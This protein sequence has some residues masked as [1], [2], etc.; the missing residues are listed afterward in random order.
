MQTVQWPSPVRVAWTVN[1]VQS[2]YFVGSRGTQTNRF[3]V[4]RI[5]ISIS[6]LVHGYYICDWSLGTRLCALVL[7]R[8]DLVIVL[9]WLVCIH[10]PC[11]CFSQPNFVHVRCMFMNLSVIWVTKFRA[12]PYIA[13]CMCTTNHWKYRDC[14]NTLFSY[15]SHSWMS[16]DIII[17]CSILVFL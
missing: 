6:S 9:N 7:W 16:F 10:V 14:L 3:T 11:V 17:N 2:L 8:K 13:A 15:S 12:I 4:I 5:R 1:K